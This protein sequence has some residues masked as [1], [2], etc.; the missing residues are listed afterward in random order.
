MFNFNLGIF[1]TDNFIKLLM[2]SCAK[3]YLIV[4]IDGVE[5]TV[6]GLSK[7]TSLKNLF[8]ESKSKTEKFTWYY[9]Y[10]N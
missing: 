6:Y 10:K 9:D 5:H 7:S 3:P 1:L 8:D 4:E 2:G